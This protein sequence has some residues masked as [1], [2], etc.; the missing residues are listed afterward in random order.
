MLNWSDLTQATTERVKPHISP[1]SI[2]ADSNAGIGSSEA[3]GERLSIQGAPDMAQLGSGLHAI[4]STEVIQRNRSSIRVERILQDYGI[5][6][7]VDT[8]EV[9]AQVNAFIADVDTRFKPTVWHVEYPIHYTNSQGQTVMGWI[10]LAL[11]TEQGWVVIDHKSSPHP[12]NEWAGIA[13][14]YSGQLGVYRQ[15]LS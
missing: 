14:S 4:T 5:S 6:E 3:F 13:L 10:D 9:I 8:A 1:S 7:A 12:R 15:A 11:E 2:V